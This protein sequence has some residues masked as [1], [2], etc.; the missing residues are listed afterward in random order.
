MTCLVGV[1][2]A[3]RFTC[4]AQD[5]MSNHELN[6]PATV[7]VTETPTVGG[8]WQAGN[9]TSKRTFERI[10]IYNGQP[11]GNEFELAPDDQKQVRNHVTQ[12]WHL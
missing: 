8:K 4:A 10:S 11:G 7:N 2:L 3:M 5:G 9:A 12:V 6:C 1:I